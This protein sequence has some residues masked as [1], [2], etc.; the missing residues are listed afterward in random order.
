MVTVLN[1]SEIVSDPKIRGGR[2]VLAGT[3]ITVMNI[4]LAN[5]TG[6]KLAPETIAEHYGLPLG[7]VYA[8]LSYYHLH[9]Q[10]LDEQLQQDMEET[11]RLVA[12]LEQQGKL[13]RLE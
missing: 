1:I 10:E 4:V 3:G 8:A 9:Q 5:T 12:E 13:K 7:Q 2:P 11:E 6:D